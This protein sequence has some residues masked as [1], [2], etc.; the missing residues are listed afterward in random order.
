MEEVKE[1]IES[2]ILEL[3]VLGQLDAT[4]MAEVE[5]MAVKFPE[6]KAELEAIEIALENYAIENAIEPSTDLSDKILAHFEEE[7]VSPNVSEEPKIVP[8]H[9]KDQSA[10]IRTLRFAL[11][12]CVGLLVI[13]A[14]ALFVIYNDLGRAKNQIT[15]LNSQNQKFAATASKLE[16]EN[17]GMENKI[18]MTESNEWTTVK[19]AG[20]NK[21]TD[22]KMSVY[23]NKTNKDVVINYAAISLPTTDQSHEFQLWA[24]VDGK[25]VSLGVF[26][27]NDK[28]KTAVLKMQAIP[29]AQAF[30]V[31]IEP[32]GGS[33]NPTMEQMVVMGAVSI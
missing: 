31:T 32:L 16:F 2:G 7:T 11:V 21:S 30:A 15:V 22:A 5:A 4:E 8:L 9:G 17:S 29:N 33:V 3:Y 23:W 1:Y 10:T 14:S 27:S 20:V 13:C 18:A 28:A 25:P 24:L 6:V 26:A 19:L 12:A